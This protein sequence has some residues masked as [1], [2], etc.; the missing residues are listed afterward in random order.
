MRYLYRLNWQI[1]ALMLLMGLI[2]WQIPSA[3]AAFENY[4]ND[5]PTPVEVVPAV[6][7]VQQELELK[8]QEMV[9]AGHM[10]PAIYFIG[11]GGRPALF[12]VTPSETIYTLSAAYPYLSDD[13]KAQVKTFL[14][15]EIAQYPPHQVGFYDNSAG[16]FSDFKGARR[17]YFVPNPEQP[18]NFFGNRD[19]LKHVSTLYALWL[20]G[21]NTQEWDYITQNYDSLKQLYTET[22]ADGK[23]DNYPELA[24]VIGFARIAQQL[25]QTS[26]YNDAVSFAEQGFQSGQNFDQ[27]LATAQDRFPN[28]LLPGH[29]YT[30]PI[31]LFNRQTGVNRFTVI[32]TH[33]NRDIGR[34]LQDHAAPQAADY[35]TK[36]AQNIKLWWLT[37]VAMTW[38]ENAYATPEIS[39]TNFMLQAYILNTPSWQLKKYLDAP[40]RKGD[41]LY[42]QKLV[43]VIEQG[44]NSPV[45]PTPTPTNI[46]QPTPDGEVIY[47][48]VISKDHDGTI[49]TPTDQP[50]NTPT[51]ATPTPE[52]SITPLPPAAHR[53]NAPYITGRVQD[54]VNQTAIFWFGD[55]DNVNNHVQVRVGY[56]DT[57]LGI[58]VTAFDRYVW[59]NRQPD[60]SEELLNWDA[61]TI[62]LNTGV[63]NNTLD[64]NS[65]RFISQMG[66]GGTVSEASKLAFQGQGGSW[67]SVTLD[68][69]PQAMWQGERV[70]DNN[71]NGDRGWRINFYIPFASLGLTGPPADG[72]F[73]NMAVIM[74]DRDNAN[75][76]SAIPAKFWP[77][78]M[79]LTQPNSW[80][81]LVF[82]PPPYQPP[83]TQN[84][85]MVTIRQ[86]VDGVTNVVDST[87]GGGTTCGDNDSADGWRSDWN[88]WG[89]ANYADATGFNIQNQDNVADWPCFS[90]AYLNF[91]LDSVPPGKRIVS[92]TLTLYQMGGSTMDNPDHP[93]PDS[94]IQIF[95]IDESWSDDTLSWNNAPLAKE[96]ILAASTWVEPIRFPG[97][98]DALPGRTWDVTQAV[99]EAY[100]NNAPMK[101]ALYSADELINS[102][103]TF[104]SSDTG[105][106]NVNNRPI[107]KIMFGDPIATTPTPTPSAT[108]TSESSATSTL[109]ATATPTASSSESTPTNT[110]TIILTKTI[111]ATAT[112]STT[113]T[114][115]FTPII[116]TT[117]TMTHTPTIT[118]TPTMT[119]TP[120]ITASPTITV[121]P[122]ITVSA[123]PTGSVQLDPSDPG[124]TDPSEP[125]TPWYATG[126][127]VISPSPVTAGLTTTLTAYVDNSL[128]T[129]QVVTLQY[130]VSKAGL[131]QWW[132]KVATLTNVTLPPSSTITETVTWIPPSDGHFC[133]IVRVYQAD[134][135]IRKFQRNVNVANI[136]DGDCYTEEFQVCNSFDDLRDYEL[137][138]IK[139][140]GPAGSTANV[141]I[142]K[143]ALGPGACITMEAKICTPVDSCGSYVYRLESNQGVDG[144]MFKVEVP[145]GTP[146]PTPTPPATKN[147]HINIPKTTN[148]REMAIFWLGQIDQSNNYADVRMS[149]DDDQLRLK[150]STVDRQ[151]WYNPVLTETDIADWDGLTLYLS[152]NESL[153]VTDKSYRFTAQINNG[154]DR[155]S[156]QAVAQG[157]ANSWLSS[158]VTFTT[159]SNYWGN[160]L[161]DA[162]DDWGWE[163]DF[164][165][166][167]TNLG[168]SGP[169]A[170]GTTWRLG[171]TLNDRDSLSDTLRVNWPA[172]FSNTVPISWGEIVFN[173]PAYTPEVPTDT[174]SVVLR[175]GLTT[176]LDLTSTIMVTDAMVGGGLDCGAN[177]DPWTE[178]GT[179]NYSGTT[180]I[181]VQN[182]Q[183]LSRRPCFSKYYLSFPLNSLPQ[184][185]VVIT[186]LLNLVQTGNATSTGDSYLQILTVADD[187]DEGTINWNNAPQAVE[188]IVT[189]KVVPTSASDPPAETRVFD[190]SRAVSE[191]YANNESAL[192]LVIYTAELEFRNKHFA[193]SDHPNPGSRPSLRLFLGDK[194]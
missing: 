149:Y 92:A 184:N 56:N 106:W 66:N 15:A 174:L 39:W 176:T 167:F 190:I 49:P 157:Q 122:V 123:T 11:L 162:T 181:N 58:R 47:L 165:I 16:K 110:P 160:V 99:A 161:N 46:P 137:N 60:G 102:G 135:T 6:E 146:T 178:W 88:N 192:R 131:G 168:L 138:L 156:Y 134:G 64:S 91:P 171:L 93:A 33:F 125:E 188:N 51:V 153:T 143:F 113:P 194:P 189:A 116:T 169:P 9:D 109:T 119:S 55:V 142:D 186:G 67:Q 2:L 187:W 129:T 182:E 7:D 38:G 163:L 166:P 126:K 118:V 136:S 185:K 114:I 35:S 32:A 10:A 193:T 159:K 121:T 18:Y 84:T 111:T 180:E 95:T 152:Q 141:D 52:P 117:P 61:V 179:T 139:V 29:G 83:A 158:T 108:P 155:N 103:K 112:L 97:S 4:I 77:A 25:G 89:T 17:E 65:Y 81:Q 148:P 101:I 21:N 86:G 150:V 177:S 19:Q 164:T 41:L 105:D 72:E 115:T 34:F 175:H 42:M 22:K 78:N 14:A 144:I 191:A 127:L 63:G 79:I 54:S 30:T 147:S 107:L 24:G 28:G 1:S 13:L 8:V 26:D 76:S 130:L 27:F 104:V 73:W 44:P 172:S 69:T 100:I 85:D 45:E 132:T 74:H 12:Y 50:T 80:G 37:D 40:T 173:R 82:N 145:C 5:I 57:E 20:Y 62:L 68:F 151:L 128:T 71:D 87:V 59:F 96:N 48:P 23:I 36:I 43:A 75:G 133:F 120:T 170:D 154:E 183:N 70:N 140:S 90:K 53:V 94:L 31:F 3:E 124:E 98:W